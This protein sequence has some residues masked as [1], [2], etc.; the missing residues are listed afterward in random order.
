MFCLLQ[1]CAS[2]KMFEVLICIHKEISPQSLGKVHFRGN[3]LR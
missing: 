2:G 1:P 3:M